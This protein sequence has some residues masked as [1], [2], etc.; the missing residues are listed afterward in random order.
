MGASRLRAWLALL[1][2]TG[3][4]LAAAGLAIGATSAVADSGGA[5]PACPASN[6]P[7]TMSLAGGSPQTAPLHTTFDTNLQVALANTNGCPLTT[8]VAGVTVTFNA[9]ASGASGTFATSGASGVTVGSDAS[10]VA[11]G[12]VFTANGSAGS[13]TIVATSAYGSVSFAMTNTAARIPAVLRVVGRES[14]SAAV[15]TRYRRPLEVRLLDASGMALAGVKVTY[16]LGTGGG[17]A[18]SGAGATGAGANFSS[19]ATQVTVTTNSAGI[20]VS[21]H[22][23]AS[24]IAGRFTATATLTDGTKF[25]SFALRNRAGPPRRV[26]AGAAANESAHVGTRFPIRLGVAVTDADSNPVQGVLVTFSA[27][28]GGASGTFVRAR[29]G[30]AR[31]VRVRTSVS[32]IA[33][34]PVFTANRAQGGYVVKASI[35]SFATAFALVNEPLGQPA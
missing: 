10:G 24:P 19:G 7:N 18:A 2:L 9:P 30:G 13:Y 27:P 12:A 3:L 20:A 35:G 14:R 6:P 23:E 4:A 22:F 1:P 29:N 8:A 31:I 28:L 11:S 34:A 33:V 5:N 26:T 17:S 16:M 32:G 15:S 21:P 25:A